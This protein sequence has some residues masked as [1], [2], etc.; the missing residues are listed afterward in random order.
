MFQ[1]YNP[2][3]RIHLPAFDWVACPLSPQ[4]SCALSGLPITNADKM[5]FESFESSAVFSKNWK[6]NV[7]LVGL[8]PYFGKLVLLLIKLHYIGTYLI[9]WRN[10][11]KPQEG[12]VHWRHGWR[13]LLIDKITKKKKVIRNGRRGEDNLKLLSRFLGVSPAVEWEVSPGTGQRLGISPPQ[14]AAGCCARDYFL[15]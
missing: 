14:S 8:L 1:M 9:G 10:Y 13:H 11:R 3:Y 5:N 7:Q 6:M 12:A 4:S 15:L 2:K